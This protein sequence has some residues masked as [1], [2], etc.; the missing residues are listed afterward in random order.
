M[1]TLGLCARQEGRASGFR[2]QFHITNTTSDRCRSTLVNCS[3]VPSSFGL[4]LG[5]GYSF[6]HCLENGVTGWV[7]HVRRCFALDKWGF[8]GVLLRVLRDRHIA[9]STPPL[10]HT[11]KI[12]EIHLE[13]CQMVVGGGS[14]TTKPKAGISCSRS[15]VS[16][17]IIEVPRRTLLRE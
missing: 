1:R 16:A 15:A 6:Q 13:V 4:G 8:V 5:L 14:S 3:A 9:S 12:M 17:D 11:N 7:S 10:S 2:R